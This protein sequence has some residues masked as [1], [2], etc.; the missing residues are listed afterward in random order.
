MDENHCFNVYNCKYCCVYA[1]DCKKWQRENEEFGSWRA[2]AAQ[3]NPAFLHVPSSGGRTF[4]LKR[5][6]NFPSPYDK[7]LLRAIGWC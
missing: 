2:I 6:R 4:T 5:N 7:S 3:V 1:H